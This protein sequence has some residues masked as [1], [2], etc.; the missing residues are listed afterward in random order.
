MEASI[1]IDRSVE[2]RLDRLVVRT[3]RTKAYFLR[4]MIE[5]SLEDLEDFYLAL[6]T[7]ENVRSGKEKVHSAKGLRKDLKLDESEPPKASRTG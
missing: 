5:S 4:E 6:A 2:Q 7:M 1:R 3:G